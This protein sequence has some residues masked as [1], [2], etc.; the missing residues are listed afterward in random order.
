MA[1]QEFGTAPKVFRTKVF[2]IKIGAAAI[3]DTEQQQ[4]HDRRLAFLPANW[5][6]VFANFDVV[7][8][9]FRDSPLR[10][11]TVMTAA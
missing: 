6:M 3:I 7:L 8:F 9:L 5:T 11:W 10:T 2:S 1:S 4:Q